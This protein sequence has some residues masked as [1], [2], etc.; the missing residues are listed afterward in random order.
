MPKNNTKWHLQWFKRPDAE[1][2]WVYEKKVTAA[3]LVEKFWEDVSVTQE[4]FTSNG[5]HVDASAQFICKS[6][7]IFNSY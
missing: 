5:K 6:L 3:E 4:A 1:S 2:G 7:G